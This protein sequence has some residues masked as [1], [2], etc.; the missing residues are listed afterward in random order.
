MYDLLDSV[1]IRSWPLTGK[2]QIEARVFDKSLWAHA[3]APGIWILWI[4]CGMNNIQ[5]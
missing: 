4:G 2:I 3:L 5:M 1:H